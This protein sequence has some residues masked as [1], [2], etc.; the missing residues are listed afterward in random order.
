M[1]ASNRLGLYIHIP[2]CL[3]KC[4]YCDFYSEAANVQTISAATAPGALNVLDAANLSENL[5][6]LVPQTFIKALRSEI[7]ERGAALNSPERGRA[8]LDSI[9]LGGGTP[10]LLTPYQLEDI[11]FTVRHCFDLTPDCEVSLEANPGSLQ[12]ER[13]AG[14]RDAGLNRL[15][16]GVQSFIDSE[17]QLLGRCHDVHDNQAA[18][19]AVRSFGP[20][21]F[22]LDL[23][24][25]L[26]GQTMSS[27]NRSLEKIVG[28]NPVHVSAY[29]LQVEENTPM[30]RQITA[31]RLRLPE[32]ESV[33]AMY[34]RVRESLELAG[35]RQYEISNYARPGRECRHNLRYW[36]AEEYLG[37]GPGAVS[38]RGAVRSGNQTALADYLEGKLELTEL[39]RMTPAE[40]AV[41][42]LILGLRC[43]EGVNLDDFRVRFD[44][45]LEAVY[46][47]QIARLVQ[48]G[49][50]HI[51][52]RNISLTGPAL[53]ISNQVFLAFLP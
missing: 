22:S 24:I 35:Y 45:D 40:Q 25:G 19:E 26:P 12:P 37:V 4:P 2:Y 23:I 30:G 21:N 38:M 49:L 5:A 28:A 29:I 31:G 41:D 27:L 51:Q 7:R 15:S 43:R 46:E 47:E 53:M 14:Y 39:E 13:L 17:L 48:E 11:M 16:L 18:L 50:L 9:Y 34:Y 6:G 3:R 8:V 32:D 33:A 44:W 1:K 10:S 52:D 42:A 36:R 20:D